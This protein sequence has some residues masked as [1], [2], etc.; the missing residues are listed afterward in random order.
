MVATMQASLLLILP[1]AAHSFMPVPVA[2]PTFTAAGRMSV[3]LRP[4]AP[5]LGL[6][7]SAYEAVNDIALETLKKLEPNLDKLDDSELA[8]LQGMCSQIV[9]KAAKLRGGAGQTAAASKKSLAEIEAENDAFYGIEE[10]KAAAPKSA[11]PPPRAAPPPAEKTA[12]SSGAGEKFSSYVDAV[13]PLPIKTA[14]D[15]SEVSDEEWNEYYRKRFGREPDLTPLVADDVPRPAGDD[16]DDDFATVRKVQANAKSYETPE[17]YYEA[18]NQAIAEWKSKRQERGG[19]VGAAVSDRYMDQ[20]R[21]MKPF[22][23]AEQGQAFQLGCMLTEEKGEDADG[24]EVGILVFTSIDKSGTLFPIGLEKGDALLA[25][26]GNDVTCYADLKRELKK[27][28]DADQHSAEVTV[29]KASKGV[30]E[31][32]KVDGQ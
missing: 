19:L 6:R 21:N 16:E 15:E 17:K 23:E 13:R 10:S 27:I 22:D 24:N 31:T 32:F 9:N 28:H 3:A 18:L 14:T 4:S 11:P 30:A 12:A 25:I 29:Q 26:N 8:R 1:L 7:M 5:A 2:V 20:L